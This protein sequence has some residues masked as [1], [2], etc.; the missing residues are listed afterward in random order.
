MIYG[1]SVA[2]AS[3][4]LFLAVT[5]KKGLELVQH[6]PL[7][8]FGFAELCCNGQCRQDSSPLLDHEKKTLTLMFSLVFKFVFG[9]LEICKNKFC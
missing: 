8:L 7:C 5:W 6:P 4:G 3:Q 1:T 9:L 2:M